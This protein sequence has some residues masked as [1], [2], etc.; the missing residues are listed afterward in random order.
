MTGENSNNG[1]RTGRA[2]ELR[3]VRRSQL[4]AV[5]CRLGDRSGFAPRRI[6]DAALLARVHHLHQFAQRVEA[7]RKAGVRVQLHQDFLGLAEGE[8]GV[9]AL[10]QR[11]VEPGHVADGHGRGDRRDRL[12]LLGERL[13][14]CSLQAA[15]WPALGWA[16]AGCDTD[17]ATIVA[18]AMIIAMRFM[19]STRVVLF[20]ADFLHPGDVL[21]TGR[22]GDGQVGHGGRRSCAVP[23]LDARRARDHVTGAD[24]L[25]RLAPFL[26][27]ARPRTP[28]PGA[29]R[30]DACAKQN[31]LPARRSPRHPR[32]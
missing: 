26:R 18:A 20:I 30:P 29:G 11:R 28:R 12:L 16:A 19:A 7:A 23:V 25:H 2:R 5:P 1:P 6:L 31:A 8:A 21:A 3:L 15:P 17:A 13:C 14:G 10:V 32:C 27:Q 24:D 4:R 22:A 9:Q